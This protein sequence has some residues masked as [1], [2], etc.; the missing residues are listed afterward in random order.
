MRKSPEIRAFSF[1]TCYRAIGFV[2]EFWN[3]TGTFLERFLE[4]PRHLNI[5]FP[6]PFLPV[7]NL[8]NKNSQIPIFFLG[9][10]NSSQKTHLPSLKRKTRGARRASVGVPRVTKRAR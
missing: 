2:I 10:I 1:W 6:P 3:K 9:W 5:G 7:Q 8:T 4:A